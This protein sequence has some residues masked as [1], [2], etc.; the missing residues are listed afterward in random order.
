MGENHFYYF[1]YHYYPSSIITIIIITRKQELYAGG[2]DPVSAAAAGAQGQRDPQAGEGATQTQGR[3]QL[4]NIYTI[5]KIFKCYLKIFKDFL[6]RLHFH[7][8]TNK[9]C[10]KPL[11]GLVVSS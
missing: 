5:Q 2:G 8:I 3:S 10:H 7:S 4:K 1:Y 9:S 11:E 6:L